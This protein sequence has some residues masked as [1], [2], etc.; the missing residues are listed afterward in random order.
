MVFGD[1]FAIATAV[2]RDAVFLTGDPAIL[3]THG[4]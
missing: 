4:R 1:A 3:A 2:A